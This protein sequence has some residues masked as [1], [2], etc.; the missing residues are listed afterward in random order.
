MQVSIVHLMIVKVR[1]RVSFGFVSPSKGS[2]Y[3]VW[4]IV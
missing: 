4:N 3:Q 2:I 1:E